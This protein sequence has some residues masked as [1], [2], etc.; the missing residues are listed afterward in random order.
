MNQAS[1]LSKVEL[2]PYSADVR[3]LGYT[4]EGFLLEITPVIVI[5][6]NGL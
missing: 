3:V 4:R 2:K 5:L 1:I 6:F